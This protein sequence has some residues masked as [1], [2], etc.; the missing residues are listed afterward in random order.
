VILHDKHTL[1]LC[2]QTVADQIG[3]SMAVQRSTRFNRDAT[4]EN[5]L[6]VINARWLIIESLI[7]AEMQRLENE[8]RMENRTHGAD[9]AINDEIPDNG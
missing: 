9:S 5:H 4:I 3:L 1:E 2:R 6:A 7:F 8:E